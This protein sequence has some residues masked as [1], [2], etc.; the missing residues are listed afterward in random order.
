M[1]AAPRRGCEAVGK[2]RERLGGDPLDGDQPVLFE[3]GD[4]APERVELA[5]A[6]EDAQPPVRR[7]RR[8][9]AADEVVGV[10]RERD[11]RGIGQRENG[12]NAALHARHQR[13]EDRLPFVVGEPRGVGERPAMGVAGR[14]RPEMMAVRREMDAP[15]LRRAKLAEMTAQVERHR[16]A[17]PAVYR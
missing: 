3:T 1:A 2:A 4:L 14:V 9:E 8:N 17:G 6:G 12:G 15:R 10:G 16:A 5:V 11:G 7:Q 13:A